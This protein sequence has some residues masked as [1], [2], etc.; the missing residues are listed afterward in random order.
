MFTVNAFEI[1]LFGGRSVLAPA[2]WGT[3]SERVNIRFNILL[4]KRPM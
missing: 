3:G 1:L 4:A 2:Q